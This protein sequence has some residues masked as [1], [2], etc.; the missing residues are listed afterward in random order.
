GRD[1]RGRAVPVGSA[2][3]VAGSVGGAYCFGSGFGSAAFGLVLT[4]MAVTAWCS[5]LSLSRQ[6]RS[7]FSPGL[8]ALSVA[9]AL[10]STGTVFS[11]PSLLI[12]RVFF[13]VSTETT[14][15]ETLWVFSVAA[16]A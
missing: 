11:A 4:E 14:S 7:T 6:G 16:A 5:P 13:M 15:A 9:V 12:V 2:R 10:P 1:E 8:R 3:P